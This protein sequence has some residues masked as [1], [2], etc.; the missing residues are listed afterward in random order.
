MLNTCQSLTDLKR[1]FARLA[2]LPD[3]AAISLPPAGY[4]SNEFFNLEIERIFEREWVPLGRVEE[5]P[6]PGDYFT[7]EVAG[8][9]LLIVRG[10]DHQIRV[11]S[12]V[13]RT[14][15]PRLPAGAEIHGFLCVRTTP[16]PTR[17]TA[18]WWGP[19]SWSAQK[20]STWMTAVFLSSGAR[21]GVVFCL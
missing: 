17:E 4:A 8:D 21:Y 5:I 13:C 6:E 11:L 9:P 19:S 2:T 7:T 14:N 20:T 10:D 12:N 16:G 15:G 3:S 1:E 18:S